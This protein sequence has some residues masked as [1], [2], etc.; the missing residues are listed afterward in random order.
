MSSHLKGLLIIIRLFLRRIPVLENSHLY[1]YLYLYP[2]RSP[3]DSHWL[4]HIAN[5]S[6]ITGWENG[7]TVIDIDESGLGEQGGRT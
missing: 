1:L 2:I 7:I 4:G 5:L 6:P 3:L